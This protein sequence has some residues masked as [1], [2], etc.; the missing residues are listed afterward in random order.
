MDSKK[1]DQ[2]AAELALSSGLVSEGAL[3]PTSSN[4]DEIRDNLRAQCI[5]SLYFLCKGI[6]GFRDLIPSLHGWMAEEIQNPSVRRLLMLIPRGHYKSSVGTMGYAVWCLIKDLPRSVPSDLTPAP[7]CNERILLSASSDRLVR[8]FLGR[9]KQSWELNQ[10]FRWLFPETV[11]DFGKTKWSETEMVIRRAEDF[12]DP[13]IM[14]IGVKGKITGGHYT[15]QIWDDLIEKEA[16]ESEVVMEKVKTFFQTSLSVFDNPEVDLGRMIGTRWA[17][18][19]LYS[20]IMEEF[21]HVE[22]TGMG[23]RV[24]LRAAIEDDEC[25]FPQQAPRFGRPPKGFTKA[26]LADILRTQGPYI[27]SCQYMND[28]S[29]P[30]IADFNV[31]HLRYYSTETVGETVH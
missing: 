18:H 27:Y 5:D 3:L 14:A 31:N 9:I 25:I 24:L 21:P 1:L 29:D 8:H 13:S 2:S 26:G 12:P 10:M 19:D 7:Q 23:F 11:P 6:L 30:S 16:A 28:P 17:H 4:A 15:K 22:E 20:W